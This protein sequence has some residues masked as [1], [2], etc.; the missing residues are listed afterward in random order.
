[1]VHALIP[2]PPNTD[3]TIVSYPPEFRFLWNLEAEPLAIALCSEYRNLD[4]DTI[5]Y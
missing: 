3:C 5:L 2:Y 4:S 1:M